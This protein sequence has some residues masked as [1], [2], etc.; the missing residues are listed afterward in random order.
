M[1]FDDGFRA[2]LRELLRWRRDV[3]RFRRD[4]LPPGT[5]EALIEAACL[6]P[7][8]GLSQPWRFVIVDDEGARAAIRR[9]FAVCNADALAAGLSF[10]RG[11]SSPGWKR[12][13]VIWLF[14]PI[15]RRRKGMASGAAPCRK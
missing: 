12:R 10:M 11:S 13:P 2:R 3:R 14:S 8:V 7:S 1:E 4:A 6:A 9:N 5:L 15:A